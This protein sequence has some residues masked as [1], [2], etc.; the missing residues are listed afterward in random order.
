[1]LAYARELVTI[2]ELFISKLALL[3]INK[4][5]TLLED[6]A[7]TLYISILN[8]FTKATKYNSILISFLIVLSIWPDNI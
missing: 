2:L 7:L 6:A 5:H 3:Y 1:M 4:L 8:Y